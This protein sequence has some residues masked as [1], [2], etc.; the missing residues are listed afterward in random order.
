MRRYLH[1]PVKKPKFKNFKF[2]ESL[3]FCGE[4]LTFL[5][6]SHG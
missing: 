2:S 4:K 1:F 3:R 5:Q 6:E